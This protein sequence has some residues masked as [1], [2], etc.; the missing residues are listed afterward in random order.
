MFDLD[1]YAPINELKPLAEN[2][3][4]VDGPVIH[5]R[6]LWTSL[7]FPTRMTIVRLSDGSLWVHSP[8]E[9]DPALKAEI[10]ALG[11]VR[12]LVAP[13]KIHYWWVRDWQV[14]YPDAMSF[15]APRVDEKARGRGAV[16]NRVLDDAPV[17]EWKGEIA[18][19][20]VAGQFLCEADFFHVASRT[21]VLTDLIENFESEKLHG[22]FWRLVCRLGGVLDPHGSMPR[23]LRATFAGHRDGVR[24]AV[25]TMIGWHPRRIV[26]AHGRCYDAAAEAELRRAFAWVGVA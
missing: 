4:I 1:P 19:V 17:P 8:T 16:F 2:I 14:A 12:F 23:D 22:W 6:W 18:H 25:E 3:W 13:S 9:L 21:L 24:A 5:M 7:P 11:P 20:L 10:D 15:A 26:I